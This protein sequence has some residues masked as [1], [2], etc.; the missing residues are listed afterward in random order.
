MVANLDSPDIIDAEGVQG[1]G[2]QSI[3][4][5]QGPDI[6]LI[7]GGLQDLL[8]CRNPKHIMADLAKL[9][10]VCHERGLRTVAI[11]PPLTWEMRGGSRKVMR[12][13]LLGMLNTWAQENPTVAAV[14]NPVEMV[15]PAVGSSLLDS[16]GIHYSAAGSKMLGH[17]FAQVLVPFLLEFHESPCT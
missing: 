16:D 6:V 8:A 3:I 9:H 5:D 17:R 13:C 4:V 2:L 7:W 12:T 11:A 14:I 15:P 1:K 10:G